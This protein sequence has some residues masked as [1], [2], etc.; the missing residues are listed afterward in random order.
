[1]NQIDLILRIKVWLYFNERGN[2]L[3]LTMI[4]NFF[5]NQFN[6]KKKKIPKRENLFRPYKIADFVNEYF[7]RRGYHPIR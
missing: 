1:M 4:D 2:L 6:Y 5:L 7:K 3:I